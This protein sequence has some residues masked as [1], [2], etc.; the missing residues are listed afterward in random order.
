MKKLFFV[1]ALALCSF[2]ALNAQPRA[3]GARI[4]YGLDASYQHG[5]GERN[6]ISVDA[7]LSFPVGV[8][9]TGTYD[10]ILNVPWQSSEGQW[11]WYVGPGVAAG[12][13]MGNASYAYVGIAGRI[14]LEYRF[15]FPLQLSLDYAPV[16]GVGFGGQ[17]FVSNLYG[18]GLGVRYLF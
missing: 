1:A 12:F 16:I 9:A 6:M 11:A 4:F 15:D 18:V 13:V 14:G 17:G 7:G 3:I 8:H 2:A 5:L 10:W